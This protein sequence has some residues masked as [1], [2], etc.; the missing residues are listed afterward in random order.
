M[1]V[2]D[3]NDIRIF[4]VVG[5][6]GTLTSAAVKLKLPT[7][8]V[9]RALTRLERSLDV[10]LI[11][12]SSRGLVLTDFG[13]EYLQVCRRALRT[14]HEGSET[15]AARRERPIGLIRVACPVTMA[16]L[17]FAPLLT[18][19]LQRYPELRVEIEP[20][21]PGGDQEPREDIDVFFK[22]KAPRDSIRRVRP[23]PGAKRG[24]FA[25]AQY[26]ETFGMPSR[27]EDLV[28]H[29]CIGSGTWRLSRG[30]T[31]MAPNIQF[32]VVTNDPAVLLELTLRHSGIALLPLYMGR[33]PETRN[34][35]VPVLPRWS[36]PPVT[37]CALFSGQ[38][39]LTPKVQVL[40]DFLGEF[41]GTARDPRLHGVD[42]KGLF[43]DLRLE[44]GA[45]KGQ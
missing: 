41:I 27:P 22:V 1:D 28:A 18:E 15:L 8:T 14:L 20:Y 31:T 40:L 32:R 12:R 43:T 37:L 39:R 38:S 4:T 21:T 7:S 5:Q 13:K 24:L 25:S 35:L 19:L 6:E 16:H 2:T 45:S 23:Y 9:S 26:L 33:W 3:L 11:H 44:I 34:A 10:L 17:I 42:P 29:T 30:A 36:L